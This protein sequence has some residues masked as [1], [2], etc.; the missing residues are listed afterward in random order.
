LKAKIYR[1]ACLSGKYSVLTAPHRG[2]RIVRGELHTYN[3]WREEVSMSDAGVD[4][5]QLA[6]RYQREAVVQ[7]RAADRLFELLRIKD[8]DNVLDLGCGSGALTRR[9]RSITKGRVVGIDPAEGMIDE[10]RRASSQ[11]GSIEYGVMRAQ[12]I[13]TYVKTKGYAE[14]GS[15]DLRP[16]TFDLVFCNSVLH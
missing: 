4:F 8:N 16:H 10:A 12:D 1:V 14:P 13:N 9:I 2:A 5:S 11:N 6:S 7:Q 15:L 3:Y